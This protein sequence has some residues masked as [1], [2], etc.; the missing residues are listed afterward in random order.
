MIEWMD[1]IQTYSWGYAN[2]LIY[3]NSRFHLLTTALSSYSYWD[4]I[5]RLKTFVDNGMVDFSFIDDF[6]TMVVKSP[7]DADLRKATFKEL[8][9][10]LFSELKPNT[11]SQE[12]TIPPL[13]VDFE[14]GNPSK[15][16]A[17]TPAFQKV[18]TSSPTE[19]AISPAPIASPE[20]ADTNN[21][22]IPDL[23]L[24][25]NTRVDLTNTSQTT[26]LSVAVMC[27]TI[28]LVFS[29]LV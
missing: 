2:R 17:F 15:S 20:A 16:P 7:D 24:P 29:Y 18:D 13:P 27:I 6:S 3:C 11:G 23:A 26:F 1:R 25:A 10:I 21:P 28:A 14:T 8:I 5:E 4:Y 22:N 9:H 12:I 19:N